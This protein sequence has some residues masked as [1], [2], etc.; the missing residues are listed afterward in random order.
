LPGLVLRQ[1]QST[2][3]QKLPV[4][5]E[6]AQIAHFGQNSQG[7]DGPD[8]GQGEQP[9]KIGI[10][11]KEFLCSGVE[12]CPVLV[13][14]LVSA[15][16]GVNYFFGLTTTI[17]PYRVASRQN[18]TQLVDVAGEAGREAPPWPGR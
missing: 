11:G 12:V 6:S 4:V 18:V 3:L 8:S 17:S 2:V 7:H 13:E 9:L 16:S 10:I 5:T 15:M 1:I 14:L